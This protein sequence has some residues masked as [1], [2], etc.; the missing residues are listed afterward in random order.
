MNPSYSEDI[1]WVTLKSFYHPSQAD[2]FC[3]RLDSEGIHYR[4]LD[5]NTIRVNPFYSDALGG[6]R[7]QVLKTDLADALLIMDEMG[8]QPD[9]TPEP[10]PL[11]R[12]LDRWTGKLPLLQRFRLEIRLLMLVPLL[13]IISILVVLHITSKSPQ[14][15]LMENSWCLHHV[16]FQNETFVPSTRIDQ[17]KI[18]VSGE[19]FCNE[20]INFR[21]RGRIE[22][23]GFNTR[24]I[25]G[26]W[27]VRYDSLVIYNTD[28]LQHVFD[29]TYSIA[30][31]QN[32]TELV[33][34]SKNTV[35]VCFFARW[36]M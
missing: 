17:F 20:R 4:F 7:L 1:N 23:P 12:A 19:G 36:F 9:S 31:R 28:T 10:S 16:K 30:P 15:I 25:Q 2:L 21:T 35:I 22:I 11:Y 13:V 8:I 33:L 27:K 6:A 24:A 5:E 14:E 26:E 32:N 29:G 34:T 18:Y 3:A